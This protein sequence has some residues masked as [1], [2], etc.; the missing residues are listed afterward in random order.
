MPAQFSIC[1]ST[2]KDPLDTVSSG[3][4]PP[5]P[6]R[7]LGGHGCLLGGA[8]RQALALQDIDLNLGHIQLTRMLWHVAEFD[9]TQNCSDRLYSEHFFEPLTH[10]RIEIVQDQVNLAYIVI[11]AAQQSGRIYK[12]SEQEVQFNRK[13][14][15]TE[16]E[17]DHAYP[18]VEQDR[19]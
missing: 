3:G 16:D 15:I 4:A 17:N 19:G 2:R 5:L 7:G 8:A 10:M 6:C 14:V 18:L 1:T 12:G 11:S 13:R 9:P